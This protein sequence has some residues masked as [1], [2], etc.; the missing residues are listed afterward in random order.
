M[1]TFYLSDEILFYGDQSNKENKVSRAIAKDSQVWLDPS[2]ACSSG[3][4]CCFGSPIEI[5]TDYKG[6]NLKLEAL[7]YPTNRHG[8]FSD[9]H[10]DFETYV[11]DDEGVFVITGRNEELNNLVIVKVAGKLPQDITTEIRNLR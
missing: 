1:N 2:E 5:R 9:W 7:G 4:I 11:N 8:I 3:F 6:T 10:G